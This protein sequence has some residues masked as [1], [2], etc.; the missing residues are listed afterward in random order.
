MQNHAEGH[1]SK[2]KTISIKMLMT[3]EYN[4]IKAFSY[5]WLYCMN[6]Q[7]PEVTLESLLRFRH[8]LV[9]FLLDPQNGRLP[10]HAQTMESLPEMTNRWFDFQVDAKNQTRSLISHNRSFDD[11]KVIDGFPNNFSQKGLM[12]YWIN[13]KTLP[14]KFSI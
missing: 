1:F 4:R 12:K 13:L 7:F 5:A 9:Y 3:R 14:I 11:K 2:K 8:M 10:D 6:N